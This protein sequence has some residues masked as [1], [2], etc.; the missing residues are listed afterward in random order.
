MDLE[1]APGEIVALVGP[2]GAG[3]TTLLRL[4]AGSLLADEGTA[5][6]SGKDLAQ[7]APTALR[8]ARSR[9]CCELNVGIVFYTH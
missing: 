6:F 8:A 3:K 7:L 4:M 9:A 1:I 5:S 2:S